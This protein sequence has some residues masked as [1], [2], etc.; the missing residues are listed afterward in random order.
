MNLMWMIHSLVSAAIGVVTLCAANHAWAQQ[1]DQIQGSPTERISVQEHFEDPPL[2]K[3]RTELRTEQ[4]K[5]VDK[6]QQ[7]SSEELVT[8]MALKRLEELTRVV[9]TEDPSLVRRG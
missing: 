6:D 7:K 1:Q 5:H 4:Q 2:T 9:P 3:A 8:D